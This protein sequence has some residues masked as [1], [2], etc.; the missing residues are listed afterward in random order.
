MG[1][2]KN[3]KGQ[4]WDRKNRGSVF[5][6]AGAKQHLKS[7]GMLAIV[8]QRTKMTSSYCTRTAI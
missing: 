1:T 8:T 6:E 7:S 3:V 2:M 5:D 4:S